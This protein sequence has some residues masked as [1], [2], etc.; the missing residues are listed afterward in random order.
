MKKIFPKHEYIATDLMSDGLKL[1]YK[2]NPDIMHIQ[3]DCMELPFQDNS[4]NL[5]YAL[6]MLEHISDDIAALKECCRILKRGGYLL[7]VVPRGK[8]LYDYFDE[9]LFHKRRY[10]KGELKK[11]VEK[12]GF[13][14]VKDFHFAWICYPVFW[15]KK[16]WNRL[17]GRKLSRKE[18]LKKVQADIDNAMASPLAIN[19]MKTEH[20]ISRKFS[21]PFGVRE[22]ILCRKE[23]KLKE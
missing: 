4:I 1:S 15:L 22:F 16:K 5:I 7:L 6:N 10:A 17:T 12:A 11:K 21:P 2:R 14:V 13:T 8:E 3:C 19:M 23:G 9:M 18:K 20:L